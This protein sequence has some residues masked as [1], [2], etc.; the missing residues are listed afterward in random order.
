[1]LIFKEAISCLR[2]FAPTLIL[3]KIFSGATCLKI[4]VQLKSSGIYICRFLYVE[5]TSAVA[6]LSLNKS[7]L[8]WSVLWKLVV[9]LHNEYHSPYWKGHGAGQFPGIYL[10][11]IAHDPPICST[12]L[13]LMLDKTYPY[14]KQVF[15]QQPQQQLLL[16]HH[17]FSPPRA[18]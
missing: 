9:S 4:V 17:Q 8:F 10:T 3:S 6:Y 18:I 7:S 16:D 12:A 14:N 1:M 2:R 5:H 15:H 11:I 13:Q